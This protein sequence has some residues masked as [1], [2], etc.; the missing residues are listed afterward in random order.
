MNKNENIIGNLT[1]TDEDKD[2]LSYNLESKPYHGNLTLNSDGT[3]NYIPDHGFIG[4]DTFT[5]IAQD[6]KE[7]SNTGT[8]TIE[9]LDVNHAPVVQNMNLSMT[10]NKELKGIFKATD[11]DGDTLKYKENSNPLHGTC[12]NYSKSVYIYTS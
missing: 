12:K 7:K 1:A 5:Y 3:F 8:V 2:P 6:W 11:L 10:M 9:V 4:N